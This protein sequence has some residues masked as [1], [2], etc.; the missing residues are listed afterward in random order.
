MF[1][2]H[3]S[4]ADK[5]PSYCR[6]SVTLVA[7]KLVAM[8]PSEGL[9]WLGFGGRYQRTDIVQTTSCVGGGSL[10]IIYQ[11]LGGGRPGGAEGQTGSSMKCSRYSILVKCSL[12]STDG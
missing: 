8:G 9:S 6:N 2:Y 1:C 11:I 7:G 10:A 3:L 5:R 4:G 12:N